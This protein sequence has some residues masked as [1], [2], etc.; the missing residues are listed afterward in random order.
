MRKQAR[1]VSLV[2]CFLIFFF[3][4][5]SADRIN[6]EEL[7]D[8]FAHEDTVIA[9]GQAVGKL[10]VAGGN[11]MVG[12]Q[13]SDGIIIVDGNLTVAPGAT[14]RGN[15]V[16]LGGSATIEEGATSEH[17]VWVLAPHG[18]P[19]VPIVVAALFLMGAASLILLPALFWVMGHLFKKSPWYLPARE[20][21]LELERRWPVLYIAASLGFSALMLVSFGELAWE[22]LFR[23]TMGLF[24]DSFVWLIRNFANPAVDRIM[25]IITD[26]GFGTSYIIIVAAVFLLLTYIKRW[27][28]M[29]ALA[30]CLA[31]GAVLSLLL[32]NLFHRARPDLLR[33]VQETSYSFPSGHALASMCFYGMVAFL[34]MRTIANWRGRL[35]VMMLAVI[36]IIAIGISRIYLGVHYPTDVVAGYAA[37]SMWLAFCI[38]LLMLWEQE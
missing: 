17:K 35:V 38:S 7:P 18:H 10:M 15:I 23:H 36:T 34:L 13:V 21:F 12:G 11:V 14:V 5:V 29:A 19:L 24:D 1:V 25:I 37:G 28:E 27:R 3:V 2:L 31:G 4:V 30:I 32:K 8:I 9:T 22:T 33:V 16:V 26:I 20:K 6:F